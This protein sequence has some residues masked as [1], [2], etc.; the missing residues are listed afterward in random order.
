MDADAQ[1]D[2]DA[3]MDADTEGH[4]QEVKAVI[5]VLLTDPESVTADA[6]GGFGDGASPRC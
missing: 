1:T 5:W 2:A 6:Q 4:L 3:Q